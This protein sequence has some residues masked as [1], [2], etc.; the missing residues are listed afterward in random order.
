MQT[1]RR[2]LLGQIGAAHL[3]DADDTQ[4]VAGP[5]RRGAPLFA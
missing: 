1:I 5:D 2:V 3:M 4:G